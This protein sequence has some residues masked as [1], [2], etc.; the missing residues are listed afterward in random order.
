MIIDATDLILGRLASFAAKKALLGEK[1]EI[2]NS[3]EAVIVGDKRVI[4]EK[5]KRKVARGDPHHGPFFPASAERILRRTIRNMMPH[6]RYRGK[7]ALKN[8]RCHL[9]IPDSIR[10]EDIVNVE[11]AR[12]KE[13]TLKYIKMRE[14]VYLLRQK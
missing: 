4:L 13:G 9:G 6:R 3:R 5:Y 10:K 8:I 7:V 12:I 11:N 14:L 2:V 1:V